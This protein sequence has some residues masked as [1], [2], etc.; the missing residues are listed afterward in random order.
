MKLGIMLGSLP[1]LAVWLAAAL[2]GSPA[3]AAVPALNADAGATPVS[4]T[5]AWLNGQL[6]AGEPAGVYVNWGQDT[7]AW[8]WTNGLGLLSN[9]VFNL[10]V[11][12]LTA[13]AGYYYRCYATNAEGTGYSAVAAFTTQVGGVQFAGGGYDGYDQST[14]RGGAGYPWVNNAGGA[15]N[16]TASNA[17]L[18]G[19]LIATG[20]AAVAVFVYWGT[21]DCSTNKSGWAATNNFGSGI[22]NEGQAFAT[23]VSV[24]SNAMYYYRFYATNPAGE[25][26]WASASAS[27]I[28]PGPPVLNVEAG[29]VPVGYNTACLNGNFIA[30]G[31]AY[32]WVYWGTNDWTTNKSWANTNSLGSNGVGTFNTVVTG[33]TAGTVYYYRYYGSNNYGEGWSATAPFTTQMGLTNLAGGS[34]DGYD[35]LDRWTQGYKLG[36]V[37]S[38]H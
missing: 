24:N 34:F 30:G 19:T 17:W 6:T 18:N 7:N 5:T 38:A 23:N 22:T 27:F 11:T 31:S 12:G 2:L 16:V 33:L 1:R 29:A 37:F 10:G 4:V 35:A 9:G 28:A 21:N 14:D 15:T 32:L 3:L 20:S 36:T 26:G 25:E 8:S 13:G